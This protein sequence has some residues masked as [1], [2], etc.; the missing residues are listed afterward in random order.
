MR[1][2]GLLLLL[3]GSGPADREVRL[4]ALAWQTR[5]ETCTATARVTNVGAKALVGLTIGLHF[6]QGRRGGM[7]IADWADRRRLAP[8]E[9]SGWSMDYPCQAGVTGAAVVANSAGR[10]P[11]GL[12][13]PVNV[14]WP[15]SRP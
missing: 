1:W 14:V 4:D 12:S 9:S 5:G 13:L 7:H 6:R 10:D 15:D 3:S 11:D 2:L 8:G